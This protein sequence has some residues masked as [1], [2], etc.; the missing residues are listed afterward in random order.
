M[1]VSAWSTH[2]KNSA[3]GP[4]LKEPAPSVTSDPLR[5][6]PASDVMPRAVQAA[7]MAGVTRFA[8]IT[9]L[10]N[11]GMPVWQAIRP[12]SRALSVH[13]GRGITH[14]AAKLGAIMEAIESHAAENFMAVDRKAS[15]NEIACD[16]R[17]GEW[18]DFARARNAVP[19]PDN[20]IEWSEAT[21]LEGAKHLVPFACVSMDLT[22]RLGTGLERSSNGL[23]AGFDREPARRAALLELIE[24][25]AVTTWRQRNIADRMRDC[26]DLR[27]TGF[28][29]LD[30]WQESLSRAGVRLRCYH[31][32][33]IIGMPVFA[34]EISDL[35][36]AAKAFR[37]VE[38]TGAHPIPELALQR[39][40]S[41]AIQGRCAYIA[42]ARDDMMPAD[43]EPRAG[44]VQIVFGLPPPPGMDLVSFARVAGG[45]QSLDEICQ[46][47]EAA[48]L[49][50]VAF[51]DVAEIGAV[52][53]AK[54]FVPGMAYGSRLRRLA[55]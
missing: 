54:A 52:C 45:S 41:E 32:P 3:G 25:D 28:A 42:G 47:V 55:A 21:S 35:G 27:M 24:R 37:A 22:T 50:P 13:Q 4:A 53:V 17:Y 11:I 30:G 10:D 1:T 2:V 33:S 34:A 6:V 46:L 5:E 18:A 36:K 23:A 19:D 39:A 29:W 26:I 8:D 16:R 38:G 7:R 9:R 31:V 51:V 40:V 48:K 14:D 43:Y 20:L 12:L 15:W 44:A 49:G